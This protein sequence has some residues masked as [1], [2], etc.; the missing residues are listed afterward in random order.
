VWVV[1]PERVAA[2]AQAAQAAR[3]NQP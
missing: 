3:S 1:L 2:P